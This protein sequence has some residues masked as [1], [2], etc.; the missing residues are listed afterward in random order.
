MKHKVA[1]LIWQWHE[2]TVADAWGTLVDV[3]TNEPFA[4]WAGGWV[5]EDGNML[6]SSCGEIV[7]HT[8]STIYQQNLKE[9]VGTVF[10]CRLRGTIV[11]FAKII[12]VN[13]IEMT[14]VKCYARI[15][16]KRLNNLQVMQEIT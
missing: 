8:D 16:F 12:E 11:G 7:L 14:L 13:I 5:K 3:K 9:I 15:G 10:K 1:D 2:H 4:H 6:G